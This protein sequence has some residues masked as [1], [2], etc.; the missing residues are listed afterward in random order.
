VVS[1]KSFNMEK[2]K[3][4]DIIENVKDKSNKDLMDAESFLFEEHEKTKELIIE[5][6]RHMDGI[7]GLHSKLLKEIENRKTI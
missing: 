4:I 5:L 6:T 2:E 7:E 1:V 3:L